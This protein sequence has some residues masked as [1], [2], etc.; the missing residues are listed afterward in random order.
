M[1]GRSSPAH[2]NN[3]T[4]SVRMRDED[5]ATLDSI[6]KLRNVTVAELAREFI[7]DGIRRALDP[8]EIERMI[9]QQKQ[10]LLKAAETMR[11]A[12]LRNT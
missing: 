7:L 12:Q 3:S 9:E 11:G 6:A 2:T 5:H 10:Q 1:A 4:F 8:D